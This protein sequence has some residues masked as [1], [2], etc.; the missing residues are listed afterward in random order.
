MRGRG[1][2]GNVHHMMKMNE[3]LRKVGQQ[4]E[5][6]NLLELKNQMEHFSNNLSEFGNK[7][8]S[9]IKLNPE[10]RK[11][12][13][14]M[15]TE[16]GV[17]PLASKSLW[18]KTLN[19]GEFYYELAIQ[20]ITISIALRE[21]T[22]ALI[23]ISDMRKYLANIRKKEDIT[24]I[25][26]EK[27]IESVAELKCGFQIIKLSNNKKAVVTIPLTISN[28][29]NLIIQIANEN[30]GCINYNIYKNSYC[31]TTK[32]FFDTIINSLIEKG[33]VWIDDINNAINRQKESCISNNSSNLTNIDFIYW[34]PGL[35]NN[36][37]K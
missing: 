29:T 34:F 5:Q 37:N 35:Y 16:I 18:N 32:E 6:K 10:F 23:E 28:D 7:Y 31:N 13:Y 25:D 26:I 2:L 14:I 20:I 36:V 22:G 21:K 19:L 4:I 1:G 27:A 12:F 9:E 30:N 15:C 33:I 24:D 11:E 17:D 8:K 3:G